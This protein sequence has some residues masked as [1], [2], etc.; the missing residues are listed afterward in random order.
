MMHLVG[1]KRRSDAHNVWPID[2]VEW[3]YSIRRKGIGAKI[4]VECEK[5]AKGKEGSL[6]ALWL[7]WM[8]TSC[9]KPP[10]R[11]T[12]WWIGWGYDELWLV[13]DQNNKPAKTLYEKVGFEIVTKD[14]KGTKV[15]P[16]EWQL[17]ELPVTNLCMRKTIKVSAQP[18]S[19]LGGL[20]GRWKWMEGGIA[21]V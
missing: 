21:G 17:R 2:F 3:L 4:L 9:V 20:F 13:V 18:F 11:L 7:G 5:V 6:S 12:Y 19:F 8:L 10:S 1:K 16:T 14:P 15:V